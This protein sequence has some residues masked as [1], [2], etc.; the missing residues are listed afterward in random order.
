MLS[1]GL[2]A[3]QQYLTM[4]EEVKNL[5]VCVFAWVEQDLIVVIL[6]KYCS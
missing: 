6:M 5:F 2:V 3:S 1:E 4:A